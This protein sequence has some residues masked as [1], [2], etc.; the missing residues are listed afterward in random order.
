MITQTVWNT[1]GIPIE[2]LGKGSSH[3]DS[4]RGYTCGL[5]MLFHLLSVNDEAVANYFNA[6]EIKTLIRDFVSNFFGCADCRFVWICRC[7][8][9]K[10]YVSL[11][12]IL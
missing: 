5:W 8:D 10:P 7:F 2:D 11:F 4:G 3:H 1:C 6:I 9:F 12:S